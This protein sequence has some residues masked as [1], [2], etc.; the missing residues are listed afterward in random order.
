[1][2][3][4]CEYLEAKLGKQSCNLLLVALVLLALV[5]LGVIVLR[6]DGATASSKRGVGAAGCASVYVQNPALM[7][8][9]GLTKIGR[10][11][12]GEERKLGIEGVI[13]YSKPPMTGSMWD[14]PAQ[15]SLGDEMSTQHS[16]F[17][18]KVLGLNLSGHLSDLE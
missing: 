8:S 9:E 18:S 7:H 13:N 6:F 10:G 11:Q 2:P 5:L 12:R 16:Y 15:M 4:F 1:M 14:T 17:G 3:G